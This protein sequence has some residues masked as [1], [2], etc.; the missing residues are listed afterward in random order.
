MFR[1]VAM[2]GG[3][4]VLIAYSSAGSPKASN[5]IGCS[6]VRPRIRSKRQVM[7]V[8]VYPSGWPTCKPS[9]LG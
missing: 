2:R 3:V 1:S 7:S 4:P 8:A 5:P 6:T 9:P